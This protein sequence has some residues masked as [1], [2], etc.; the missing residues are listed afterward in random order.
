MVQMPVRVKPPPAETGEII[1]PGCASLETAM[2]L[3]GARITVSSMSVR[4]RA[5]CCSATLTSVRAACSR[6]RR[7]STCGVGRVEVG[8]RHDAFLLEPLLAAER[9]LGFADPHFGF[10]QLIAGRGEL[11]LGQ[12][13]HGARR[14]VVEAR[15]HLPL[16]HGHAFLDVHRDH[17]AGDP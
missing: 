7:A 17:L 9:E 6:A 3:N 4:R 12:L 2:P 5:T 16:L 11:R 13:Q 14:G 15:E 8:R 1:S 10:E